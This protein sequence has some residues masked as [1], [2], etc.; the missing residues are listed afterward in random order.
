MN[1]LTNFVK[2]KL[3]ALVKR[4]DVPDNLWTSCPSCANMMHH[5]DL[6]ENLR[7]CITCNYHFRMTA[8]N[9]IEVLFDNKNFLPEKLQKFFILSISFISSFL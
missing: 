5:K 9:R 4:K 2:P 1:W 7:V 3:N 8:E 6:N